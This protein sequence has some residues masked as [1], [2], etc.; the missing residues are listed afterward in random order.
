MAKHNNIYLNIKVNTFH[1][2][3][4]IVYICT[5]Y[6]RYIDGH[7]SIIHLYYIIKITIIISDCLNIIQRK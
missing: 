4:M 7:Y 1:F 6:G 5:R 2:Y 3:R